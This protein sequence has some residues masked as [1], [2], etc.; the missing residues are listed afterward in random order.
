VFFVNFDAGDWLVRTM[1]SASDRKDAEPLEALGYTTWADG[2]RE[3][4]L[5][6][7]SVED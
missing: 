3:R 6:R 5:V 1:G 2:D 4:T 7:L